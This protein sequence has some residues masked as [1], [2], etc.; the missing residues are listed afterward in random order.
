VAHLLARLPPFVPHLPPSVPSHEAVRP[1]STGR[2]FAP[3][4]SAPEWQQDQQPSSDNRCLLSPCPFPLNYFLFHIT[5]IYL[6]QDSPSLFF[7]ACLAIPLFNLSFCALQFT[8]ATNRDCSSMEKQGRLR[9]Q[10]METSTCCNYWRG[11]CSCDTY[12]LVKISG[13][14]LRQL[15]STSSLETACTVV[16]WKIA[17]SI[18]SLHPCY[19][20]RQ[21]T[22]S[23]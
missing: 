18:L 1:C 12:P 20:F 6:V 21:A 5:L 8:A 4:P 16:M 15:L 14:M 19:W 7:P 23:M 13:A 11:Q 2:M 22:I 9:C 17:C 3:A 10:Y